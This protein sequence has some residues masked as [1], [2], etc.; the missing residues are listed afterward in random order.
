[1]L[2]EVQVLDTSKRVQGDPRGA[3]A[4]PHKSAYFGLPAFSTTLRAR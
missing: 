1:M 2:H 4:P 3:G